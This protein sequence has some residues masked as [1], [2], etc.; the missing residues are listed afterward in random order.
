MGTS[1]GNL[2]GGSPGQRAPGTPLGSR[3]QLA[4]VL[5]QT[6]FAAQDWGPGRCSQSDATVES[7]LVDSLMTW[8]MVYQMHKRSLFIVFWSSGHPPGTYLSHVDR[9]CSQ[10]FVTQDCPVLVPLSA[11]Q[12]DL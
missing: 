12:H 10:R 1:K 11:L 7:K 6:Y 4:T 8:R 2:S 9:T 3:V 5:E